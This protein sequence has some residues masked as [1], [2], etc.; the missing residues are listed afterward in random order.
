MVRFHILDIIQFSWRLDQLVNNPSYVTQVLY[1]ECWVIK[2]VMVPVNAF[3]TNSFIDW[4]LVRH[5]RTMTIT[6]AKLFNQPHQTN[7]RSF[8]CYSVY[9]YNLWIGWIRSTTHVQNISVDNL[10][11]SL[12]HTFSW[13]LWYLLDKCRADWAQPWHPRAETAL[14]SSDVH[15]QQLSYVNISSLAAPH[16]PTDL[17]SSHVKY[18]LQNQNIS[19]TIQTDSSHHLSDHVRII[20]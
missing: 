3:L 17:A 15:Q 12:K 11:Y 10:L 19:Y 13:R 7:R 18:K 9:G 14:H 8:D 6:I 5:M 1:L 20:W 16:A 2:A 4:L